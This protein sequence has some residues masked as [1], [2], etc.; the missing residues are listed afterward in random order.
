M[1]EE[2]R[3]VV[4]YLQQEED[5][6]LDMFLQ[7]AC[8]DWIE[9]FDIVVH[10]LS[11]QHGHKLFLRCS[12]NK[13]ETGGAELA[14]ISDLYRGAEW[15]EREVYDMFGVCFSNHPDMRRIF[16]RNNFPGYP[17]RKD[18]TDPSRVVKRPY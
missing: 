15:H 4:A 7:L 17:L 16:L 5:L 8:V 1:P 13:D 11:S 14:T 10:L 3:E 2:Y 6:G 18:F 9:H 12:L